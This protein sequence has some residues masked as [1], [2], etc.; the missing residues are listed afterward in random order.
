MVIYRHAGTAGDPI[1]TLAPKTCA[2]T[3]GNRCTQIIAP[4][5]Q[6]MCLY[7]YQ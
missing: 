6:A 5:L 3:A 4:A 7:Y 1:N 2:N